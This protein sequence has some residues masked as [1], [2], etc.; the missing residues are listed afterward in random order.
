MDSVAAVQANNIIEE[1]IFESA[2][3]GNADSA[4]TS[5]MNQIISNIKFTEQTSNDAKK[6]KAA[7]KVSECLVCYSIVAIVLYHFH[8]HF[9]TLESSVEWAIKL[10][11]PCLLICMCV[12]RV[13]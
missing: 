11:T 2:S 1:I 6:D 10:D 8:I 4:S 3:P 13:W 5:Q 9:F 7:G 12:S